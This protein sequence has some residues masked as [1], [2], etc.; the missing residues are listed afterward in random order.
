MKIDKQP[1]CELIYCG[2]PPS[3]GF[4]YHRTLVPLS[5]GQVS[6]YYCNDGFESSDVMDV[7]VTCFEYIINTLKILYFLVSDSLFLVR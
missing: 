7:R 6:T 2:K 5:Y 1:S 4:S 3:N